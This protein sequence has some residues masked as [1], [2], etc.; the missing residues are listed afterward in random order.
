MKIII[1]TS[2]R[3]DYGLLYPIIK[4]FRELENEDFFLGLAVTGTHLTSI[5]SI[6]EIEEDK[7]RIDYKLEISMTSSTEPEIAKNFSTTVEKFTELFA[8]ES[9]NAVILLG[10]R[11]EILGVAI[12]ALITRVP[13]FH[14]SGGDLSLGAIDNEIRNAITKLSSLHFTTN[15]ESKKRVIDMG[16]PSETVYNVGSTS[17]DNILREKLIERGQLLKELGIEDKE[18]RFLLCTYHPTTKSSL[19]PIDEIKIVMEAIKPFTEAGIEIVITKANSDLGGED[20]NEFLERF[21]EKNK[22]FYLFSSL[23]RLRY[24]SLAKLACA[25]IG[26]SSSGIVEIPTL[27]VPVINIGDRQSGRT[28]GGLVIDAGLDIKRIRDKV[29]LVLGGSLKKDFIKFEN[30]YGDGSAAD[31]IVRLSMEY[32]NE[33]NR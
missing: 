19:S 13:I 22:G 12:A 30:P 24:F 6:R 27:G 32:L 4:K 29:E 14:I 8:K 23:G 5:G 15:E 16:E 2:T 33:K 10:D 25:V 31:R 18:Q 11:Y 9:P 26:N 20:I 7:V 1:V 17:I 3:A 21:S 28:R